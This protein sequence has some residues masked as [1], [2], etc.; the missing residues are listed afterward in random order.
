MHVERV[1]SY[2]NI[3]SGCGTVA[4]I[5]FFLVQI[6]QIFLNWSRKSTEG[7]SWESVLI[8]TFGISFHV[9]NGIIQEMPFPLLLTGIL[10]LLETLILFI[11]F[12]VYKKNRLFYLG[13]LIPLLPIILSLSCPASIRITNWVNPAT[14]ILCYIPLVWVCVE[15]RTTTGISLFGQHLNYMGAVLGILMCGL[16]CQCNVVAW[17]FYGISLA[18]VTSVYVVAFVFDEFRFVDNVKFQKC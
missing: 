5:T 7:L 14:Q 16:N 2:D 17:V 10:L 3:A 15:N 9:V 18:Q 6:P 8:R 4:A 13:F 12:A 1:P 11:Q